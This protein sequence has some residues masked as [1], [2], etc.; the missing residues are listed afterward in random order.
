MASIV[1]WASCGFF[2]ASLPLLGILLCGLDPRPYLEMPPT[3]RYGFF[4]EMRDNPSL[5][6]WSYTLPHV[7]C[8][9]LFEMPILGY[10]GYLPFGLE[11]LVV[12]VPVVGALF[13]EPPL[14]PF[15]VNHF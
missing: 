15:F 11:C 12:G 5:A 3:N 14:K 2:L 7:S 1:L 4:W 10:G 9:R 8:C 13:N 6:R